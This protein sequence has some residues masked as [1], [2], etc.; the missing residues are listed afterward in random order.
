MAEARKVCSSSTER[1]RASPRSVASRVPVR[2]AA[3]PWSALENSAVTVP[4][5]AL[6]RER[7]AVAGSVPGRRVTTTSSRPAEAAVTAG[8]LAGAGAG[9][10]SACPP[11]ASTLASTTLPMRIIRR[12]SPLPGRP[13]VVPPGDQ[14][15]GTP[16]VTPGTLRTSP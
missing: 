15:G 1:T 13:P 16:N 7:A 2:V 3:K 6:T 9:A 12:P 4:P 14:R 5:R 11:R 10:T 8:G